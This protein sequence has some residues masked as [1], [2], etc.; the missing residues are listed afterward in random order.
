V[1]AELS[2]S[3]ARDAA[4][5]GAEA[6]V[7]T[8]AGSVAATRSDPPLDAPASPEVALASSTV[9]AGALTEDV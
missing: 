1:A 2:E 3:L 5:D 8:G 4:P 6:L 9:A 7:E